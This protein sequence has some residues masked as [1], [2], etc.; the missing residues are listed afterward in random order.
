MGSELLQ[1]RGHR[2][3][4]AGLVRDGD[5]YRLRYAHLGGPGITHRMKGNSL[6]GLYLIHRGATQHIC[7]VYVWY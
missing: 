2:V 6:R 3:G 4:D 7:Q 5:G 1:I